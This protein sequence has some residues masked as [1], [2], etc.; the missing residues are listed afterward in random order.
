MNA[1][2]PEHCR[3]CRHLQ[4]PARPDAFTA[5]AT[6]DPAVLRA[7]NDWLE[8]LREVEKAERER[9]RLEGPFRFPP[10]FYSWC[11]YW[12]VQCS[13]EAGRNETD[14]PFEVYELAK[15]H[16]RTGECEEFDPAQNGHG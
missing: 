3:G 5:G 12:T 2:G 1:R 15:R 13:A 4:L 10:K 14:E 6:T 11:H 9:Y 8:K 16:N 7:W